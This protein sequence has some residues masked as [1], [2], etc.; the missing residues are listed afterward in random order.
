MDEIILRFPEI[1][2][3]IFNNLDNQ[4]LTKC[5]AVSQSW[6]ESIEERKYFWI[7]KIQKIRQNMPDF[8]INDRKW[9]KNFVKTDGRTFRD[10]YGRGEALQLR[11]VNLGSWLL[12]ILY[13]NA[14]LEYS[15][16][17]DP[18]TCRRTQ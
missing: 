14:P 3:Q 7:R 1:S 16:C 2:K 17:S 12:L 5:R 13:S 11:G 10:H 9:N 15:C 4:N 18:W 8:E 6:K